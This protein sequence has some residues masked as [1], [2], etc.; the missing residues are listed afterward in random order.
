L[1]EVG[2]GRKV[3][4]AALAG[5]L[6]GAS[7]AAAW[8]P[9][10]QQLVISRAI[11]SLPKPLEKFYKEHRLEIPSLSPDWTPS[12]PDPSRRFEVDRLLP[13]PFLDLPR[14]EPALK[15]RF[16]ED[17]STRVGR[18]PWLI[19]ESYQRL[20]EDFRS[21][22]KVKILTESDLLT[23]LVADLCNPLS[24]TENA[25]GQKSGQEGLHARFSNRSL[26]AWQTRLKLNPGPAVYLDAPKDYV[27]S[28]INETY[29]WLDNVLYEEDLSRRGKS[30]YTEIYYD[31]LER[32][33]G[34]IIRERLSRAAEA[35][36]S[37]WYTAWTVAGRPEL[38]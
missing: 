7:P 12:P 6:L 35:A 34:P 24:L 38:K 18:L 36:G 28:L 9:I 8:S 29:V 30:G 21:S 37:Y 3:W 25:D 27:F 16:G 17:V 32:R 2:R 19:E 20:V 33:V 23:G 13:F 31:D 5:V 14:T 15:A 26:E 22:D 1:N 11:D 4:G 10:G